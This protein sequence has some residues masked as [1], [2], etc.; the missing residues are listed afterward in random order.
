MGDIYWNIILSLIIIMLQ[1]SYGYEGGS[2]SLISA[3]V[4]YGLWDWHLERFWGWFFSTISYNI[5]GHR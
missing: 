5:L 3:L 2:Q 4:D 1:R